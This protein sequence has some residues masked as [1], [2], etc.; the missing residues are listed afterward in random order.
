VCHSYLSI[1]CVLS[2]TV[3]LSGCLGM[4]GM[5][6]YVGH[7]KAVGLLRW[8]SVCVVLTVTGL[9][10]LRLVSS[11]GGHRR[12]RLRRGAEAIIEAGVA[13]SS[14]DCLRPGLRYIY[15]TIDLL[16]TKPLYIYGG[17]SALIHIKRRQPKL[18]W[19][20]DMTYNVH[21]QIECWR[22]IDL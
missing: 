12:S 6:G 8:T 5:S 10:A 17:E 11:A 1:A 3:G 18:K 22:D 4:S 2:G 9:E 16:L 21:A 15:K 14:V 13:L 19:W 7:I 20:R